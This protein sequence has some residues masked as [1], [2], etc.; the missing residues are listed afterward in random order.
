MAVTGLSP[1]EQPSAKTMAAITKLIESEKIRTVFF[2][3]FVNDAVARSLA[4]ECSV[5]AESLQPLA[6]LS[7][8]EAKAG[9]DYVSIMQ[10]NLG[11]LVE[12][13]E[14]R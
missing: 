6:N 11:K 4:A 10:E 5:K 8:D 14:C 13:L 2:E 12:A 7:A 9:G 1:D 3:A